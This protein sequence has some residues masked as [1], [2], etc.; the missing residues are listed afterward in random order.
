MSPMLKARHVAFWSARHDNGWNTFICEQ[1]D[2]SFA[3]IAAP[4]T[5]RD[6]SPDSIE[7]SLQPAK[8]SAARA[9]DEKSGHHECSPQCERWQK[10]AQLFMEVSQTEAEAEPDEDENRFT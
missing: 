4:G 8:A 1:P 9:L 10:H 6:V 7:Q 5:A 3:V 2:G